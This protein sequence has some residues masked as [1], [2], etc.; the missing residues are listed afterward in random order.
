MIKE[1]L[2]RASVVE[3]ADM[4]LYTELVRLDARATHIFN[5]SVTEIGYVGFYI[6]MNSIFLLSCNYHT[7]MCET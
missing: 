4:L 2:N 7:S 1:Q 6:S 3:L 5:W